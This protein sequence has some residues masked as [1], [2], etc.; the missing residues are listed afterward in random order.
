MLCP[1]Y[2]TDK[3]LSFFF[4]SMMLLDIKGPIDLLCKSIAWF[5]YGRDIDLKG[6]SPNFPSKIKRINHFLSPLKSS[7]NF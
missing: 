5:P 4:S 2:A 6:S 3:V 1:K 7:E